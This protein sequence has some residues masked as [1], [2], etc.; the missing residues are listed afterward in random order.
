MHLVFFRAGFCCSIVFLSQI[1]NTKLSEEFFGDE[2]PVFA[3][4]NVQLYQ[5]FFPTIAITS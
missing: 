3:L 4:G 2:S 1:L 5:C